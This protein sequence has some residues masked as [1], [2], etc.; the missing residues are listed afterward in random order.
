MQ[1]LDGV[2]TGCYCVETGSGTVYEVDLDNHTLARRPPPDSAG[3]AALRRD[4]DRVILLAVHTCRIG[5]CAVFLIDLRLRDVEFTARRSTVVRRIDALGAGLD[6][7]V[8]NAD[9]E[10]LVT[11]WDGVAPGAD[12]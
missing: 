10:Q 1:S 8:I 4:R 7:A 5:E 6:D 11:D 12:D 2:S 9:F 3:S